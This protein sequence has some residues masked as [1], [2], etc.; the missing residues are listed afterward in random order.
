MLSIYYIANKYLFKQKYSL[1]IFI[2]T[3]FIVI[4]S[5]LL[6]PYL[7]AYF[8]DNVVIPKCTNLSLTIIFCILATV[9]I[10]KMSSFISHILSA[11]I[12]ARAYIEFNLDII[13]H[14]QKLPLQYFEGK[15]SIHITKKI[16]DD[17][18]ESISFILD[19]IAS[20]FANAVTI[21]GIFIIVFV[22][23][24][25]FLG[26]IFIFVIIFDLLLYNLFKGSIYSITYLKKERQNDFFTSLNNQ[27]S[28]IKFLKIN[29]AGQILIE[30]IISNFHVLVEIFIKFTAKNLSY[31]LISKFIKRLSIVCILVIGGNSVISGNMTIGYLVFTI[32]YF[33][34]GFQSL[35]DFPELGKKWQ[36]VS[37]SIDR[38][39]KIFL[40]KEEESGTIVIDDIKD[41][42]VENL[43]F[44]YDKSKT[45]FFDFS[46][47]FEKGCIYVINGKNG[48]GK[49]TFS[50]LLIG[51][52]PFKNGMIKF[53][54]IP[55]NE[56]DINNLRK[57]LFGFCEQEPILINASVRDNI[58]FFDSHLSTVDVKLQDYLQ[59]FN[60]QHLYDN[61]QFIIE[62]TNYENTNEDSSV[63]S[64]GEKQKICL[65]RTFLKKSKLLILDEPTSA[66]D[67]H[68]ISVLKNLLIEMKQEC[69][70]IITHNNDISMIADKVINL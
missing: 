66:L 10:G 37:V 59:L 3:N 25:K 34:H 52:I 2:I 20:A 68:S 41:I 56:L 64:G 29:S 54:G 40:E 19:N 42:A 9:V 55:I 27:I 65:V 31:I 53:N 51:L 62:N 28:N 49:S 7:I 26:C 48:V 70:I 33:T 57:N 67:S 32:T 46:Y 63:V 22:N 13:K 69:I 23:C 30:R 16:N 6:I 21:T 5:T 24:G 47:K 1:I 44:G 8:I 36:S 18:E 17:A 61:N 35:D 15:D 60:I 4:I 43:T 39:N 50:F 38:I 45:I 11:K 14:I 58:H 12:H